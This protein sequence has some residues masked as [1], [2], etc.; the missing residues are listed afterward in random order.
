MHQQLGSKEFMNSL[1]A[2]LVPQ[3]QLP[4]K[5][6]DRILALLQKWGLQ[7]EKD[8]DILPLYSSVYEALKAKGFAFPPVVE[9]PK[10][11]AVQAPKEAPRQ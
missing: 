5:V 9:A 3:K 6:T 4:Q 2:L 8:R 7:F 1:V 10:K 11:V